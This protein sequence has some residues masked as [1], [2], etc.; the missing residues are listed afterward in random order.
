MMLRQACGYASDAAGLDLLLARTR[1]RVC[2]FGHH[3]TRV[4]SE[5]AGVRCIGLNKVARP[6]NLVAIGIEPGR[7]GWSLLGEYGRI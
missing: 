3:H 4:D 6:G 1:P 2:F 7:R 5:I